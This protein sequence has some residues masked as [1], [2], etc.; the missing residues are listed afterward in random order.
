MHTA[1]MVVGVVLRTLDS[2]IVLA[3]QTADKGFRAIFQFWMLLGFPGPASVSQGGEQLAPLHFPLECVCFASLKDGPTSSVKYYVA[4]CMACRTCHASK[5]TKSK[6]F[7][8]AFSAGT[9]QPIFFASSSY[10]AASMFEWNREGATMSA[11]S[12]TIVPHDDPA[13]FKEPLRRR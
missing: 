11:P 5:V 2:Q 6:I 1:A 7:L 4:I 12:Q 13:A 8:S 10:F 3:A 9:L